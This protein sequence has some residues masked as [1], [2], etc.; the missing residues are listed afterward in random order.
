VSATDVGDIQLPQAEAESGAQDSAITDFLKYLRANGLEESDFNID[1]R[2]FPRHFRINPLYEESNPDVQ[3]R[4]G[5]LKA[6]EQDFGERP[7]AVNWLPSRCQVFEIDSSV[8]LTSSE[9]FTQKKNAR[10]N[11]AIYGIDA[12][13]CAAALA[14]DPHPGDN[15]LDVCCAP[16]AKLCFLAN[17]MDQ[18]GSLTGVD[19]SAERLRSTWKMAVR[20]GV[21]DAHG[22]SSGAANPWHLRIFQGDGTTFAEGPPTIVAG[23]QKWSTLDCN[24]DGEC[25]LIL[26]SKERAAMAPRS[27]RS[28]KM[29]RTMRSKMAHRS[30][31]QSE[32]QNVKRARTTDRD[33][34]AKPHA[35]EQYGN[36]ADAHTDADATAHGVMSLSAP[37]Q[38]EPLYDRVLVD[39]ECT[40]DGSVRHISKFKDWGWHTF[41]SRVL[42][43]DRLR[44]LP[45]LQRRLLLNGYLRLRPGG[46]LVYS[47]CSLCRAQNEEVV[48]WFLRQP[49]VLATQTHLVPITFAG[50]TA[51]IPARPCMST[52]AMHAAR[53]A[54]DSGGGS[55]TRDD[56]DPLNIKYCFRLGPAISRSSGLFVAK[57]VK[58]AQ[59]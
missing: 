28:L 58:G 13:S 25:M 12:S 53:H 24:R 45:A 29:H 48:E 23:R 34:E 59:S 7:R 18:K 1:P 40:H 56:H 54:N 32:P 10:W 33:T 37:Q 43:Q 51:P 19:I 21:A 44:T 26:D 57:F 31:N 46:T 8:K 39:A 14:L 41:A 9:L 16:G 6:L 35:T 42:N 38:T 50:T 49:D 4:G 5:L 20:Y 22:G 3:K 11:P 52:A 2:S 55:Q 30:C 15:V 47:T 27:K 17:L 36:C